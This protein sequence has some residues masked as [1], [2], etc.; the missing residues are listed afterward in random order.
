MKLNPIC[1]L[2]ICFF[3]VFSTKA[4]ANIYFRLNGGT[5]IVPNFELDVFE[6]KSRTK[7]QGKNNNFL[8]SFAGELVIDFNNSFS[9][10]NNLHF[11]MSAYYLTK[12]NTKYNIK[13]NTQISDYNLSISNTFISLGLLYNIFEYNNIKYYIEGG[14]AAGKVNITGKYKLKDEENFTNMYI[15]E[16]YVSPYFALSLAYQFNTHF[17][18]GVKGMLNVLPKQIIKKDN[19]IT[20]T[21]N[22][23]GLYYTNL[24]VYLEYKL[25]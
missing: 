18:V 2:I 21:S 3:I 22:M 5:A 12:I 9:V 15:S 7:N 19:K 8:G 25:L 16:R 20:I 1:M 11:I 10:P 6:K 4:N 23:N 13:S 17:N 24:L 14:F